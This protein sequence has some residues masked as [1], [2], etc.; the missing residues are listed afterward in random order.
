MGEHSDWCCSLFLLRSAVRERRDLWQKWSVE[1]NGVRSSFQLPDKEAAEKVAVTVKEIKAIKERPWILLWAHRKD[2]LRA[3][4]QIFMAPSGENA[5]SFE[6]REAKVRVP[7]IV[8]LAPKR[9][10][11]NLS[12]GQNSE[13]DNTVSQGVQA[14]QKRVRFDTRSWHYCSNVTGFAG[15]IDAIK[16]GSWRLAPSSCLMP[17]NMRQCQNPCKD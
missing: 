12:I 2:T 14:W 8:L 13:I 7:C 15:M 16:K 9:C 5:N 11:G 3:E 1:R 10:L 6:G 4:P 17:V